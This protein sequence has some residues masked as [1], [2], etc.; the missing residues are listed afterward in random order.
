MGYAVGALLRPVSIG[1]K[2]D[3]SMLISVMY[4]D[5]RRRELEVEEPEEA[6]WIIHEEMQEVDFWREGKIKRYRKD[7]ND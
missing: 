2:G 6:V 7:Y 1:S 3:R 4:Y 5:G